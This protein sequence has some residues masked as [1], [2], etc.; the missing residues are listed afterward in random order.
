MSIQHMWHSQEN[1]STGVLARNTERDGEP[2]SAAGANPK[3]KKELDEAKKAKAAAL[4]DREAAMREKDQAMQQLY[5]AQEKIHALSSGNG[6]QPPPRRGRR[7]GR[8]TS[9]HSRPTRSG[10]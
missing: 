6:G 3:L 8:R 5:L 10:C 7:R 1:L 4:R 2:D 9:Q